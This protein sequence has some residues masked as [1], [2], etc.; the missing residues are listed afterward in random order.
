[1]DIDKINAFLATAIGSLIFKWLAGAIKTLWG[2]LNKIYPEEKFLT[3]D[4]NISA[5][6][7]RMS[8]CKYRKNTKARTKKAN[9]IQSTFGL[10][11]IIVFTS[12][13][14][15]FSALLLK[16][17]VLWI[18]YTYSATHDK[19]WIKPGEAKNPSNEE[20]WKITPETCLSPSELKVLAG[21]HGQTKDFIC[22]YM[23][24][25]EEKESLAK[26][27]RKTSISIMVMSPIIIFSCLYF[28]SLGTG[29]IID[30]YITNRITK[31][32]HTEAK[33]SFEYLT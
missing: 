21:I 28:I 23:L 17:P 24:L 30:I 12:F 10:V 6:L 9:Y 13:L 11:F 15:S 4:L 26:S 20:I 22:R 29:M 33:K 3:D 19:F 1:M 5:P 25:S 32:N 31:F 7:I 8:Y 2:W 14:F 16:G 27:T 18:D